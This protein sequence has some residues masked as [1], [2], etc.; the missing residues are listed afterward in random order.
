MYAVVAG[1]YP[2]TL[3]KAVKK[4]QDI[5]VFVL[6]TKQNLRILNKIWHMLVPQQ[7]LG[8]DRVFANDIL[9]VKNFGKLQIIVRW[10]GDGCLCDYHIDRSVFKKFHHVTRWKL[11]VFEGFYVARYIYAD[12]G[13]VAKRTT[14]NP[15]IKPIVMQDDLTQSICLKQPLKTPYPQKHLKN[16]LNYGP[17]SLVEQSLHAYLEKSCNSGINN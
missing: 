5:D 16:I 9:T 2:A 8:Y 11:D 1:S 6:V 17:P 15:K 7:S 12:A 13:I 4:Y 14:I 3:A 10:V